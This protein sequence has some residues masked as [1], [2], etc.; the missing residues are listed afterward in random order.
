MNRNRLALRPIP[1]ALAAVVLALA[2]ASVASAGFDEQHSF[3]ASK[4]TVNNVIGEITVSGHSGSEF[5]VEVHVRGADA[6]RDL[7]EIRTR[8]GSH[9]E[10]SV[11]F[12]VKSEKNYVYPELGFGSRSSFTVSRD[13]E[14]WLSAL[15]GSLGGRKI[16]VRGS[17][18]GKEVWAD[19]EIRV[20]A[21]GSL[22]AD[23][24][25]GDMKAERVDGHIVLDNASGHIAVST[26]NGSV[27]ADTGSGHVTVLD[28]TGDLLADTGSGHVSVERCHG[29]KINVDTG[30]G[31]V[32]LHDVEAS[33]LLVDTGSGHVEASAVST[34]SALIDTG[35]GRVELAL[36]RMGTGEFE[37]DTGSGRVVLAIPPDAS[38]D[39]RAETGS[40]GIDIDLGEPVTM[41]HME[42]DEVHFSVGDGAA[43]VNID[44]GSGAIRFVRTE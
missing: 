37:I 30:S 21:G 12:P 19:V 1:S 6:S 26:V 36:D 17:G 27:V 35:S 9:S 18:R 7:I 11:I 25:V 34:E 22:V 39:I 14:S 28:V 15:L 32:T 23:H 10:L 40:G 5:E 41:H 33:H 16:T 38:A 29:D 2:L 3:D 4:L 42:R 24:Y 31:H 44:T 20:P 43:R 8:D 13:G